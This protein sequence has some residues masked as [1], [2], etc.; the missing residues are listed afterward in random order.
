MDILIINCESDCSVCRKVLAS[1]EVN[2][3]LGCVQTMITTVICCLNYSSNVSACLSLRKKFYQW[4][5]N[6][7]HSIVTACKNT[8]HQVTL[9]PLCVMW[10]LLFVS[11]SG[12]RCCLVVMRCCSL[13]APQGVDFTSWMWQMPGQ[14]SGLMMSPPDIIP[15]RPLIIYMSESPSEPS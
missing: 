15:Q 9:F 8:P 6:I 4:I 5:P 3:F 7:F 13:T 14:P 10:P 12:H 2:I 1:S 11:Q